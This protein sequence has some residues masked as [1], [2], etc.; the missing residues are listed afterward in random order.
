MKSFSK[1]A[2]LGAA[3]A[4]SVPFA[5]ATPVGTAI[6]A[7]GAVSVTQVSS[8]S[9]TSGSLVASDSGTFT[10]PSIDY[11]A[12]YTESVYEGGTN[13]LCPTCLEFVY[14]VA[15]VSGSSLES[16]TVS[17]FAGYTDYVAYVGSTGG[18]APITSAGDNLTGTGIT[19]TFGLLANGES[20]TFVVFTPETNYVAANITSQNTV[21]GNSPDLGPTAATPEPNSL[22]LLGSG[23]VSAAGLLAR[24][25]RRLT[26]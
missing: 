2:V 8:T 13:A 18:A 14:T 3:V 1:L 4:A 11:T 20:D 26:A 12:T 6:S 21:A 23:L 9:Y 16:S 5:S 19:F 15:D 10:G 25:R 22:V 24:R 17:N 7:G